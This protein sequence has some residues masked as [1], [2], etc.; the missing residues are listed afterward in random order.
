MF[1]IQRCYQKLH[2]AIKTNESRC[3][4]CNE[5]I[6]TINELL[7][8]EEC[9]CPNCK[10]QF[11]IHRKA[12]L[13]DGIWYY[14]LY[15]YNEFLE[16][17]LFQYKEQNDI[18]LA[19]VFL[20][21]YQDIFKKIVKNHSI[22]VMPSSNE[23]RMKRGFEPNIK[24]LSNYFVYSP[25]YKTNDIKQSSSSNRKEIEEVIQLKL[26]YPMDQKKKLLFDDVITSG[27]TMHRGIVLLHP[28]VVF[29]LSAHPEWI[30]SKS[31]EKQKRF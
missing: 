3:L 24:L 11:I 1:N 2:Q 14:V 28:D 22:C 12:Y 13:I 23:R 7:F 29:L 17:L 20:K 15:E 6:N 4:I 16:R 19:P 27:H 30:A 9:I 31:M 18:A 10:S 21:D 5:K 25:F 26:M 8:D